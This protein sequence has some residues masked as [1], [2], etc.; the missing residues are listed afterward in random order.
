MN[1]HRD[2]WRQL[3]PGVILIALGVLFL[4]DKFFYINFSSFFRTWW[5]MLLIG[6]GLL[7]LVSRPHRPVGGLVLITIGTIFQVDRLD[8]FPWWS[9][10]RMWPLILIAIGAAM[11][12]AR[13][14][15]GT[16]GAPRGGGP[17]NF[18]GSGPSNPGG[19]GRSN[20]SSIE[21]KS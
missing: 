10:H 12:I 7:Q 13:L 14:Q 15:R 3:L 4:A 19:S 16:F 1:E 9:M 6:F 20:F 21:V 11:L 18:G 2:A 17:S 5:P 8:L